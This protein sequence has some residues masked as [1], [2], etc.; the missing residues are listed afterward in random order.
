MGFVIVLVFIGPDINACGI[1][2]R[3]LRAPELSRQKTLPIKA[4]VFGDEPV[5]KVFCKIEDYYYEMTRSAT[6][7]L[8]WEAFTDISQCF[9]GASKLTVTAVLTNGATNS[10]SITHDQGNR[11]APSSPCHW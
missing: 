3:Y 2:T 8:C 1:T 6:G 9:L 11:I 5:E 10:S 4:L 7:K